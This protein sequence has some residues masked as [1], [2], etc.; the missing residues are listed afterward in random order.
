[1]STLKEKIQN[2]TATLGVRG[3]GYVGLPLAVEKVKDGTVEKH[4][5]EKKNKEVV[6]YVTDTR[7]MVKTGDSSEVVLFSVVTLVS[8]LALLAIA[9]VAMKRRRQ[10]KGE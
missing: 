8:G 5:V 10:D 1:M 2:K 6:T 4:I 9:F 3:L 7:G